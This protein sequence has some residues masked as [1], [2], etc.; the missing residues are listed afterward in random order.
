MRVA[1][2]GCCHGLLDAAFASISRLNPPVDL[3]IMCGDFQAVRDTADLDSMSVPPRYRMMGDFPDYFSGKKRAPALTLV[4]GGN[5]EASR[6]FASYPRGGWLAP[7]I[8]YLGYAG[9]VQVRG[10]RIAGISGIWR[11]EDYEE[12]HFESHFGG[13]ELFSA[14]HVRRCDVQ[15]L[16]RL[17]AGYVDIFVSHDWPAG[18]E[19]CGNSAKLLAQKP[20]F[21]RDFYTG[22]LGS[23]A[24]RVLLES[25]QPPLWLAAHLHCR[26]EAEWKNKTRFLALD[27]VGPKR[28]FLE[29]IDVPDKSPAGFQLDPVWQNIVMENG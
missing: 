29:V 21:K 25:L 17:G 12:P 24:G 11:A 20:W 22:N 16:V 8:W 14:Y 1:V 18:I 15:Q 3:I 7:N 27:K 5:H 26:Y 9:C 28:K 10:V 4:V 23:P 2:I 6:H 13:E 19:R